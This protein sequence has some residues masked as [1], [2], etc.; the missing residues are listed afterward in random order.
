[1]GARSLSGLSRLAAKI[2]DLAQ[3]SPRFR[4]LCPHKLLKSVEILPQTSILSLKRA[5]SD[6]LLGF[7][8]GFFHRSIFAW[9]RRQRDSV[10]ECGGKRS[11]DSALYD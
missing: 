1:M 11:A 5:K 8:V 7:A 4:H 6:R 2:E 9:A 10:V 3:I